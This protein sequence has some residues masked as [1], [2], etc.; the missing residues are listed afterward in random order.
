M[1]RP[2]RAS[3]EC[4]TESSREE[5]RGRGTEWVE[6][7]RVQVVRAMKA[8]LLLVGSISQVQPAD[9]LNGALFKQGCC[10]MLLG[11]CIGCGRARARAPMQLR[12][13]SCMVQTCLK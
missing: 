6:C 3:R 4:D 10:H 11:C 9:R 2:Q 7:K 12:H 13:H 8:L 1:S 5:E